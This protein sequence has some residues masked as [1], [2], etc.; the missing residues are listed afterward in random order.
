MEQVQN[1]ESVGSYLH[2]PYSKLQEIKQHPST[3]REKSISV[4]HYWVSAN[5]DASWEML[6]GAFYW[7]AEEGAS[8]MVT[9][10]LPNG[11]FVVYAVV[12]HFLNF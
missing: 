5:P 10:Y 9:Q 1:W 11:T 4:G 3:V 6:A 7:K 8:A 12:F 2:V